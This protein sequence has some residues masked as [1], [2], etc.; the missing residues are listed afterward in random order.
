VTWTEAGIEY[1]A[2]PRHAEQISKA[3]GVTGKAVTPLVKESADKAELDT[4]ELTS[5]ERALYRSCT[6]RASYL[7]QDRADLPVCVRELA[8]GMQKPLKHHWAKLKRLGRYLNYRPRVVQRFPYQ[9]CVKTLEAWSDSNHAGCIRTRKSTSGGAMMAGKV[10]LRHYARGQ[11]IIAL[12]SGEAEY[13]ALVS[14][15]AAALGDVALAADW[16]VK[17]ELQAWMDATAGISIGSRRD[18]GR[19]KHIDTIFLWCQEVVNNGRAKVGKKDATEML[20]DI[21]TKAVP[22]PKVNT[23]MTAMGFEYHT[24]RHSLAIR[25]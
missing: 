22:E 8:Q 7:A 4:D 19:V 21:L 24:G 17:F 13:Y 10:C 9:R 20:A 15:I 12:S 18:L 23:M 14:A 16:G 2:D 1:E 25:S 11:G 5:E 6:M 3:L